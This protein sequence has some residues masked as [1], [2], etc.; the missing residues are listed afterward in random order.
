[1]F[2]EPIL[3][4]RIAWVQ[5]RE[6]IDVSRRAYEAARALGISIVMIANPGHWL[7]DD[8]GPYAYL[9][10]AFIP[11]S[12]EVDQWFTQRILNAVCEYGRPIDGVMTISDVRLPEI[13]KACEILGLPTSP[14]DAYVIAGDKARTRMLE[15]DANE[16]FT[17]SSAEE[18]PNWLSNHKGKPLKFPLIV[19]SCLGWNSDCVPKVSNKDELVEGVHRASQRHADAANPSTAVVVEPYINGPQV[20]ANMV[21]LD[22]EIL[23][24]DISDDFPSKGDEEKAGLEGTSRRPEW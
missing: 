24:F 21:L 12:I 15:M 1:M 9:R 20:D 22:G 14:Y 2:S 8:N 18:L 13:A 11:V 16:S 6:N 7:E 17:L 5:G 3:P 23:F 19:K 4:K 10:E